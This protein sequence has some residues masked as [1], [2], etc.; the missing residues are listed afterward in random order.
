MLDHILKVYT[1][2]FRC[3]RWVVVPLAGLMLLKAIFGDIAIA[4]ELNTLLEYPFHGIICVISFTSPFVFIYASIPIVKWCIVT[5]KLINKRRY[6][7][8]SNWLLV[9]LHA[10]GIFGPLSEDV[11][12]GLNAFFI[13]LIMCVYVMHSV[14]E[15]IGILALVGNNLMKFEIVILVLDVLKSIFYVKT[16]ILKQLRQT[17]LLSAIVSLKLFIRLL[18]S[19]FKSIYISSNQV[20]QI[21]IW[22]IHNVAM[23]VKVTFSRLSMTVKTVWS[24]IVNGI[25]CLYTNVTYLIS[26]FFTAAMWLVTSIIWYSRS[27]FSL[28]KTKS[29]DMWKW[30]VE[31][32]VCLTF[33]DYS[34]LYKE[35]I[36][37]YEQCMDE[38][39]RQND[40]IDEYETYVREHCE[41]AKRKVDKVK[42]EKLEKGEAL[43]ELRRNNF[44][45]LKKTIADKTSS[46]LKRIEDLK[47]KFKEDVPELKTSIDDARKV[48][49]LKST[50]LYCTLCESILLKMK[51]DFNDL[52]NIIHE[53]SELRKFKIAIV[54]DDDNVLVS[55][56]DNISSELFTLNSPE[57]A[58]ISMSIHMSMGGCEQD[59]KRITREY[60]MLC[61][62]LERETND[63]PDLRVRR[64]RCMRYVDAM[65]SMSGVGQP[66]MV[67]FFEENLQ[68]DFIEYRD[69][70]KFPADRLEASIDA[71]L[72]EGDMGKLKLDQLEDMYSRAQDKEMEA[73]HSH[74]EAENEKIDSFGRVT[75]Q[76]IQS[77]KQQ[78]TDRLVDFGVT[79]SHYKAG[80]LNKDFMENDVLVAEE[81][82]KEIEDL[83]EQCEDLADGWEI[84]VE[85]SEDKPKV[86]L[87]HKQN[88]EGIARGDNT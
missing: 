62:S 41:E 4:N 59:R 74:C 86:S 75:Q 35:L 13:L 26:K 63:N 3:L 40:R 38:L 25:N 77:E 34:R 47:S 1:L 58:E 42:R 7:L 82:K 36:S 83:S 14:I 53:A 49:Q 45:L 12:A 23:I 56:T 67:K 70:T 19:I 37:K 68:N 30:L 87:R 57:K 66:T 76:Q 2:I 32:L 48:L 17:S 61:Q 72:E 51:S 28:I 71:T 46:H 65:R 39:K 10:K 80:T 5:L 6:H 20:V 55:I 60:V 24:L 21:A 33:T 29:F 44:K 54:N 52:E 50:Q 9:R 73:L 79:L 27:F 84:A 18:P 64:Q 11:C 8:P 88:Q 43:K 69:P 85:S 15:S 78:R 81:M 31:K 22:A 16:N